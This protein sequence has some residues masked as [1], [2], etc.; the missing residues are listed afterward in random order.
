MKALLFSCFSILSGSFCFSQS[1]T[2]LS[3]SV[4]DADNHSSLSNAFISIKELSWKVQL[5]GGDGKALFDKPVPP[6]DIH[7]II[8]KDGYVGQEG[9]Y[10]MKPQE[11]INI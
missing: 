3:V 5:T 11:K 2:S 7:Y 8:S 4:T 10:Y 6:G 9:T 1:F